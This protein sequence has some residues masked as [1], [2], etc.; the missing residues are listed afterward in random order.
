MLIKKKT[1][2]EYN[3]EPKVKI[4]GAVPQPPSQFRGPLPNRK[5]SVTPQNE[6]FEAEQQMDEEME[7]EEMQGMSEEDLDDE[8]LE[9]M[10]QEEK[11]IG[12]P[13]KNSRNNPSMKIPSQY[14]GGKDKEVNPKE[15]ERYVA[16]NQPEN[17][18]I[19]DSETGEVIANGPYALLQMLA[20]ILTRL[21]RIEN[22]IGSM[23]GDESV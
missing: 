21:E 9:A 19:M 8:D 16:F 2:S 3:E 6:E 12:K 17:T 5:K 18:G 13:G 11:K 1:N 22:N 15:V 23:L 14:Q 7:Q 4:N 20:V 10:E